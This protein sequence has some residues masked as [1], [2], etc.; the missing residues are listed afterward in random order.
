[1]RKSLIVGCLCLL[2]A[3]CVYEQEDYS[4]P[5]SR[6]EIS[7]HLFVCN[8]EQLKQVEEEQKVCAASGYKEQ[9]CFA[10]AKATLCERI[11]S[12]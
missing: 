12:K 4:T 8:S 10:Q 9:F 1:M 6:G 5:W 7:P 3:G 2:F 11:V